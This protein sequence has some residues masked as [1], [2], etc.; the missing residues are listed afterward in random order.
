MSLSTAIEN[1][2]YQ[3]QFLWVHKNISTDNIKQ[4]NFW[5][6]YNNNYFAMQCEQNALKV[7]KTETSVLLAFSKNEDIAKCYVI[8]YN[9]VYFISIQ[10]QYQYQ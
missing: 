7:C 2:S 10:K 6:L 9:N 4:Y 1:T 8:C 3:I 5:L